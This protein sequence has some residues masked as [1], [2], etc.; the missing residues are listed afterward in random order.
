[1]CS[2]TI[3]AGSALV[4]RSRMYVRSGMGSGLIASD[5]GSP[6]VSALAYF[7]L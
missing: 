2:L 4:P 7:A 1:M 5:V 6:G 3:P